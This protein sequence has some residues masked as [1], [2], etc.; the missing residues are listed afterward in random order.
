MTGSRFLVRL[1]PAV[2]ALSVLPSCIHLPP[3]EQRQIVIPASQTATIEGSV[4]DERFGI[5]WP[6]LNR[7]PIVSYTWNEFL[8]EAHLSPPVVTDLASYVVRVHRGQSC[9]ER[10]MTTSQAA[11][12]F[13]LSSVPRNAAVGSALLELSGGLSPLD[14]PIGRGTAEQ[15]KVMYIGEATEGWSGGIYYSGGSLGPRRFIPS[16]PARPHPGSN[17]HPHHVNVTQT[18]NAWLHGTRPN[19]GFTITPDMTRALAAFHATDHDGFMCDAGFSH[20]TLVLNV[21]VPAG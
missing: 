17:V 18:V 1:M 9:H 13:D 11:V 6:S 21:L 4:R 19:N 2:V 20:A 15:C 12:Q 8:R 10:W 3:L 16:R 5:C 14:P 7:T